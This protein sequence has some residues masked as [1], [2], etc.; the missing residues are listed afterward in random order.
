VSELSDRLV[1]LAAAEDLTIL[2]D[3]MFDDPHAGA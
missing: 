1:D 3:A 2:I